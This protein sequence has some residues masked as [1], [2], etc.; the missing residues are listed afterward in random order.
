MDF[1]KLKEP[2]PHD[3]ISWRVGAT[4][5]RKDGSLAWGDSPM[6]IPLAYIDARD[7][8]ERLDAVCG[9]EN[10][11]NSHP[12]ANGKTSC[13][14]E[15]KVGKEWVGKENGC[16]DSQVEAEK[17]AFSDSFKRS[18]VQ[19]GIGRYLYDVPNIWVELKRKGRSWEIADK[20]GKKLI[21]ALKKAEKGIRV[22]DEPE[23]TPEPLTDEE[24]QDLRGRISKCSS[25]EDF[26]V[27]KATLSDYKPR[28]TSEQVKHFGSEYKKHLEKIENP[29]KEES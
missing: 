12:V 14:I 21:D 18:A 23:P 10:W 22:Q 16:G 17:G 28:M 2:F 29:D 3:Y 1:N 26:K 15:I 25:P 19:W 9:A 24:Q 11:Q 27:V 13:R 7:V 8:M 5:V 4:N 6:G 20:N